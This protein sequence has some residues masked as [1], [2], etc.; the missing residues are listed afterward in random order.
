VYS[1]DQEDTRTYKVVR[2]DE[3][4]YSIWLADADSPCGWYE[5]GSRGSKAEC[6]EYINQVWTDM[7]PR[8]LRLK[9]E[10]DARRV[11][12]LVYPFT[13]A[14]HP[15]AIP[16]PQAKGSDIENSIARGYLPVAFTEAPELP[17]VGIQVDQTVTD[18]SGADFSRETGVI[19]VEGMGTVYAVGQVR[20][21]ATIDLAT[22]TGEGRLTVVEAAGQR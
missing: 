12:E 14:M 16:W 19:R 3:E 22:R 21:T 6:L 11:N 15:V 8:S 13:Q 9:M 4:Q 17:A 2:N 7:R 20:C 18:V 5:C 1:D 10:E